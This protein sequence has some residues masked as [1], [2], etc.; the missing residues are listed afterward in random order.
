MSNIS[1]KAPKRMLKA[2]GMKA[3]PKRA[4]LSGQISAKF[5]VVDR[6]KNAKPSS[7]LARARLA[8]ASMTD[9]E[10]AAITAAALADPDAQPVDE[11]MRRKGGRPRSDHPK[12][13]IALRLDRDVIERFK[14]GGDGWQT[15]MNDAL[16]R[17]AG[18][19]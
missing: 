15:R 12:Q 5:G 14:A 1:K 6:L 7:A 9:E 4:D 19:E 2:G 11:L 3:Y 16:R 13:Q 10:D 8:L 17:A 18:L